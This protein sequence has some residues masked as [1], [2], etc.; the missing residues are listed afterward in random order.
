MSNNNDSGFEFFKGVLF[1]GV[2]GAVIALLYAPK[3]GSEMRDELRQRSLE[4]RDDA[5]SKL[6]LAQRKAE[7]L[8]Q[9]TKKELE[10]LRKEA[11]AAAAELARSAEETVEHGKSAVQHEKER[12]K[13]AIDAGVSAYKQE[14]AT[15]SKKQ[16]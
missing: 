8:F 15:K 14:K 12:L 1:G 7:A 13:D 3:A 5:D 10:Q 6:E 16:T 9:E 11:E 2:V 4:L